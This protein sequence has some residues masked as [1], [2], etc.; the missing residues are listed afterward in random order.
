MEVE[1]SRAE[2]G[3]VPVENS[4]EGMVNHTLDMFVES[5]LVICAEREEPISHY[6]LSA[7]GQASKIKRVYSHPQALAQCRRWIEGHLPNVEVHESASTSEAALQSSLDG[8]AA[9]I[10]SFLASKLYN[11]KVVAPNI[12]DFDQNFTRFLVIGKNLPAR[13]GKDKTSVLLSI[14]DRVGALNDILLVFKKYNVNLTKIESRPTKKK[15]WEYLFFVDFLGHVSEP[16]VQKLLEELKRS[17]LSIKI[18]GSY[19]RSDQ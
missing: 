14:K 6:L 17:C 10:A 1:K 16:P 5:D 13:C 7:S 15:A 8:S 12:E 11:L 19:P 9:A 2:Y 3:V 4:T 18:L